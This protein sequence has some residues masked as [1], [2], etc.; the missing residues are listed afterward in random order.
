MVSFSWCCSFSIS[1]GWLFKV[2]QC[3]TWRP[4]L[5]HWWPVREIVSCAWT[6]GEAFGYSC[7]GWSPLWMA[8]R[9]G[10]EVLPNC[11][12]NSVLYA[13]L[14]ANIY[15]AWY[16]LPY[17]FVWRY[18]IYPILL[19]VHDPFV[20]ELCRH[21]AACEGTVS[22]PSWYGGRHQVP[23]LQ[24]NCNMC[25]TCALPEC[26]LICLS[27][28]TCTLSRSAYFSS[29]VITFV[30]CYFCFFCKHP[31]RFVQWSNVAFVSGR[32]EWSEFWAVGSCRGFELGV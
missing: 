30:N 28:P 23:L 16:L 11:L 14:E 5:R 9:Q 3:V 7:C 15:R 1:R 26:L 20:Q 25:C 21:A 10:P 22:L 8:G 32:C 18:I 2:T 17:L 6:L 29:I 13:E 24:S 4:A 19:V 31:D 12:I 27:C